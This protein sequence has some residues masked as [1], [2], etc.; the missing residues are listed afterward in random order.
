MESQ[1][2]NM[3]TTKRLNEA[4]GSKLYTWDKAWVRP[5]ES[6][7]SVYMNYVGINAL[8]Y[9]NVIHYWN[10]NDGSGQYVHEIH[11][12]AMSASKF[13]SEFAKRLL[14]DNFFYFP[15][16]K[17][18]LDYRT[19]FHYCPECIKQGYHSLLSQ[20]PHEDV[21]PIHNIPYIDHGKPIY[22]AERGRSYDSDTY[23]NELGRFPVPPAREEL[24]F[25]LI[26]KHI[27]E[28]FP[29]V[30]I[31][32]YAAPRFEKHDIHDYYNKNYS[33]SNKEQ[34]AVIDDTFSYRKFEEQVWDY[35][36]RSFKAVF[37]LEMIKKHH[38]LVR[39]DINV[40]DVDGFLE[41]LKDYIYKNYSPFSDHLG[42]IMVYACMCDYVKDVDRLTWPGDFPRQNVVKDASFLCS[43]DYPSYIKASY[44]YAIRGNTILR[45]IFDFALIYEYHSSRSDL[46]HNEY[47]TILL[48]MVE[49]VEQCIDGFN[50]VAQ[51]GTSKL[52][53]VVS[54]ICAKDQFWYQAKKYEA[55]IQSRKSFLYHNEWR[56][57]PPLMYQVY[58]KHDGKIIIYRMAQ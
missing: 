45:D 39:P 20:M 46:V 12:N 32:G 17:G 50:N 29:D 2:T 14:P 13:V 10:C 24:D 58:Q 15:Q 36:T 37:D 11:Y 40:N 18:S 41:N 54:A 33:N 30:E 57:I 8:T 6:A 9:S 44:I 26:K 51:I 48:N 38:V 25:S 42:Q 35:F 19:N 22:I 47:H 7:L 3:M 1:M 49:L 23:I 27:D 21:C 56:N 53:P 52:P 31:I 28:V 16:I 34:I 43:S 55:D 5:Y 4:D